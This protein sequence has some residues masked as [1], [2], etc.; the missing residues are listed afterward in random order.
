MA[1]VDHTVGTTFPD[2]GIRSSVMENFVDFSVTGCAASD[3]VR[4]FYIPA[5]TLVLGVSW[6]VITTEG[7]AATAKI[8]DGDDDDGYITASGSIDLNSDS[9]HSAT[10]EATSPGYADGRYYTAADYIDLIPNAALD[11]AQVLVKCV[12]VNMETR[13]DTS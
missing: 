3:T 12:C 11:T 7:G 2:G 6:E 1:N 13:V 4:I 8:G 10:A 5:R 9:T